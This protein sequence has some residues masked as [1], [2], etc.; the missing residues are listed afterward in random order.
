MA[1]RK[2]ADL[3]GL[4]ILVV[5]DEFFVAMDIERMLKSLGCEVVGP[6]AKLR[7]AIRMAQQ[8]MLDGA[9][10][11]VNLAGERVDPVADEL[12]AR[13]I[14]FFFASGYGSKGLPA[15]HAAAPALKKPFAEAAVAA[16]IAQA[17][18]LSS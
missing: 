1:Q 18:A 9:M 5:E 14:P 16:M 17:L 11:D 4:R 8:E 10:L 3:S 13:G 12:A 6:V 7:D 15:R 2:A